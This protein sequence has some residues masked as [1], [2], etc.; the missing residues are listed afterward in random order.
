MKDLVKHPS[1]YTLHPYRCKC[2]AGVECIKIVQELPYNVGVAVA[3]C[4]RHEHKGQAVQ[5]LEKAVQHL[6]FEIERLRGLD[7]AR[8]MPFSA[9]LERPVNG[10][11][12]AFPAHDTG[13]EQC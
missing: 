3:Y 7:P 8:N 9:S 1:H 10:L 12:S 4:W 11:R 13:D 6:Q 5:D 2:G